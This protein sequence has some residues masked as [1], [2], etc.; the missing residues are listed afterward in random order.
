MSVAQTST[1]TSSPTTSSQTTRSVRG[2]GV[3][4]PAVRSAALAL[5]SAATALA[6]GRVFRD[7]GFAPLLLVAAL[8][9]HFVGFVGRTAPE[10]VVAVRVRRAVRGDVQPRSVPVSGLGF[11]SHN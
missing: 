3:G 8:V 5:V 7:G 9:P 2:A 4:R 11:S 10:L 1:P 6:F